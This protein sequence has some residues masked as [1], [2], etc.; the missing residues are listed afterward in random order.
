MRKVFLIIAFVIV[1]FL[2]KNWLGE[3]KIIKED[4]IKPQINLSVSPT[5]VEFVNKPEQIIFDKEKYLF[6]Y[7][8]VK[9]I[10]KLFLYPNFTEK[11]SSKEIIDKDQCRYLTNANFYDTKNKPLG[12]FVSSGEVFG[13]QITSSLFNG[14]FYLSNEGSFSISNSE[15]EGSFKIALQSGPLLYSNNNPWELKII[16]DKKARRIVLGET[17]ENELIFLVFYKENEEY[18]G[19][20]LADLPKILLVF[21][22]K[23]GIKIKNA[24]NLDGGS[25]SVFYSDQVRLGELKTVGGFFCGK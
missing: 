17:N 9:E 3:K 8:I 15:K 23:T 24:L 1:V 22:Q 20:Y 2:G 7:F 11:I 21:E 18:A 16:D 12:L 6:S 14:F 4:N 13:Q 25:A 5:P 10:S 19:P